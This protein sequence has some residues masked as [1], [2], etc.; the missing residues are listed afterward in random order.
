MIVGSVDGEELDERMR[1]WKAKFRG[2][3]AEM[4]GRM[5]TLLWSRV[6][7][8]LVGRRGRM[9]RLPFPGSGEQ[10]RRRFHWF[11]RALAGCNI[12]CPDSTQLDCR[13][14]GKKLNERIVASSTDETCGCHDAG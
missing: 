5:R 11:I 9:S 14:T 2:D 8:W 3:F 13:N 7:E 10:S 6:K 4:G 1:T 12:E